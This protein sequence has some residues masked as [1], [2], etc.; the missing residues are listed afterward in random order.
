MSGGHFDHAARSNSLRRHSK[1]S[2]ARLPARDFFGGDD[3]DSDVFGANA[4]RGGLL[5]GLTTIVESLILPGTTLLNTHVIPI[6]LPTGSA[7][8]SS[9]AGSQP[10]SQSDTGETSSSELS[11]ASSASASSTSSNSSTA[12]SSSSSATASS[13][14]PVIASAPPKAAAPTNT[15]PTPTPSSLDATAASA[16]THKGLSG[17]AIGGIVAVLLI[18]VIA[19][20]IFVVRKTLLRRRKNKRTTWSAGV[21]PKPEQEAVMFEKPTTFSSTFS[22]PPPLPEKPYTPVAPMPPPMSYNNPVTPISTTLQPSLG[23]P[24]VSLTPASASSHVAIVRCTFIPSLP[25]ELSISTGEIIRVLNE[26]DDGW[27]LCA[28]ERGEQGVVPLEC[29]DRANGSK[30]ATGMYLGQGT[31]DWRMSRRAS[32][33]IGPGDA[34]AS[35]RY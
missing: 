22:P 32:S 23:A 30:K 8:L 5:G 16:N 10:T 9:T 21:F 24:A 17:G 7:T 1:R 18:A 6:A 12:S 19:V 25:D 33:L 28:N 2:P 27:A 35:T 20:S 15:H 29:L 31:G 14:P 4:H 11:S 34:T 26:Y 13:S 3:N